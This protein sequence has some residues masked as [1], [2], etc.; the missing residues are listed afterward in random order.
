MKAS[1][2]FLQVFQSRKMAAIL[3]LGFASGL[4]FALTDDAFRAWMT[5]AGLS[6]STIG[7]FSLVSLPYSLK[8]IWS[9]L[10]DRFVPPFLGRRRGWMVL[11]QIGLIAGIVAIALQMGVIATLD[12]Q[13]L[14]FN[15]QLLALTA[16]GV[17]LL[18]ATQDIAI[19]AYRADVVSEREVGAGA[20]MT[21]LGYRLALLLTGWIAFNLADRITWPWVYGLMALLM[22]AGLLTSFWAP[23][24]V[25]RDRPPESLRQAVVLPFLEF[26]RRLG[27]QQALFTLIFIILFKLGDAMVAKMAVPF[28]GGKGLGFADADIGNIR[29]G[30]GLIATIVGSLTG[31]AVL[32]KLGI[33]RSL[34]AFGGLQA[35]S[36][37]GYYFLAVVGKNYPSMV[38]AINVENFCGGLGT[39][40]FLGFLMSLCNPRFSATQFALLSSLMAVGRDLLAGPASGELAQRLQPFIQAHAETFGTLY[41][42]GATQQ[43]WALFFLITLVASLPGLLLLPLFAP[44]NGTRSNFANLHDEN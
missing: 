21:I 9:P 41:L 28:L 26:F 33:N 6:L 3:L 10:L 44:W 30:M 19:D 16:L 31:G 7:W 36:N 14:T 1:Q 17:A 13:Q 24:P 29:Q 11:A 40:G 20:S 15:L 35:L 27:W 39:A 38:A 5:K 34:W 37:L 22:G 2:S 4:P 8:F 43:G 12:P 42:A 23:E 25:E 18:S 32:S